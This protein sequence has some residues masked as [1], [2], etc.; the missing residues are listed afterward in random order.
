MAT[1]DS[2]FDQIDHTRQRLDLK[3]IKKL[4]TDQ[5]YFYRICL[6]TEDGSCSA[7]G[8]TIAQKTHLG[9]SSLGA[10]DEKK[11][12]SGGLRF[13]KLP[14]LNYFEAADY[15]YLIDWSN[16]VVT[17]SPLTMH[18]KYKDLKEMCKEE[19]FPALTL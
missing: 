15:N 6:A 4:S 3:D 7:A 9:I 1:R 2:K 14:K 19:Q 12:N 5:Q 18:I 17:E 10:R 13:S 16:C 11:K 8:L